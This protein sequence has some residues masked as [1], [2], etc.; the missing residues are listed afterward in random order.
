MAPHSGLDA[1]LAAHML[2]LHR[3]CVVCS[4]VLQC[5]VCQMP[6]TAALAT[7]R[8]AWV[9]IRARHGLLPELTSGRACRDLKPENVVLGRNGAARVADFGSAVETEVNE[10]RKTVAGVGSPMT[11][12]RLQ[13]TFVLRLLLAVHVPLSSSL[14][15]TPRLHAVLSASR[16]L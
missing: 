7:P 16:S 2:F 6:S 5:L 14:P 1:A 9:S 4:G 10:V 3:S 13:P 15:A 12:V 8:L 11:L